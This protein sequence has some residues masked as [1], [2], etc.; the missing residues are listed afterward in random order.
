M[1]NNEHIGK[2]L[3]ELYNYVKVEKIG[4]AGGKEWYFINDKY[5]EEVTNGQYQLWDQNWMDRIL[6]KQEEYKNK[7]ELHKKALIEEEKRE[8]EEARYKAEK[9]DLYG[10]DDG[11]NPMQKGKILKCLMIYNNYSIGFMTRKDFLM[12][13]L[14]NG[15]KLDYKQF[16]NYK[17]DTKKWCYVL[18]NENCFTEIT[19]TE[20]DFAQYL[21]NN[22]L[23][24]AEQIS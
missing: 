18:G 7:L 2:I 12:I 4:I 11:K 10:F 6:S 8:A 22:N 3:L 1:L 15:F 5:P 23:I 17:T 9:E 21:L 20:Y 19:K 13:R 14:K 16:T 24:K